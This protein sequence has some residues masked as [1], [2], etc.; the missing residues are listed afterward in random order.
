MPRPI[1]QIRVVLREIE[2]R[3]WRRL[4][5]PGGYSF[6]DLHVAIQS[7]FAWTDTHPHEFRARGQRD[8]IRFGMPLDDFDDNPPLPGWQHRI[9]DVLTHANPRLEYAY[10]FGPATAR[11]AGTLRLKPVR[12]W[13]I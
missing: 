7:A 3:I 9:A 10:D 12:Q 11:P 2:P 8:G 1:L 4:Q 13:Q 5:V 6:W